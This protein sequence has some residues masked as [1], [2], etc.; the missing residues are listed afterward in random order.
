MISRIFFILLAVAISALIGFFTDS[1]IH[2]SNLEP[3]LSILQNISIAVFTLAGI[4]LAYLYPE[5][6]AVYTGTKKRISD[7]GDIDAIRKIEKLVLKIIAS[8]FILLGVLFY[9]L[10]LSFLGEVPII[11]KNMNFLKFFAISFIVFLSIIEVWVILTL[12]KSNISF[13]NKLHNARSQM[14]ATKKLNR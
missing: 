5:S 14:R 9:N 1:Y 12:I 6:I 2:A 4:W 11:I 13:V 8:A 10:T 3:V 7:I